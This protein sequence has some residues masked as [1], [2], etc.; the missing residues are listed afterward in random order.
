M[1]LTCC[2]GNTN[3]KRHDFSFL[4][5]FFISIYLFIY[6]YILYYLVIKKDICFVCFF[7]GRTI[8][9]QLP[10]FII[11]MFL[12]GKI[13]NR[14]LLK[15]AERGKNDDKK[16]EKREREKKTSVFFFVLFCF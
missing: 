6:V 8:F 16:K 10:P 1:K 7:C 9:F 2:Y 4:F 14:S 13:N 5:L 11:N 3:N 15:M 12:N